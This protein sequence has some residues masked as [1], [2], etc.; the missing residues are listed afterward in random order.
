ML[1]LIADATDAGWTFRGACLELQSGELRT[2][3]GGTLGGLRAGPTGRRAAG[4]MHVSLMTRWPRSS[5]CITI[6]ATSPRSH[7]KLT[8]RVSYLERV[9]VSPASVRR[10][11]AAQG[12]TLHPASRPGPVGAQ[13]IPRLGRVPPEPDLD[14][15]HDAFHEGQVMLDEVED[16][17][18]P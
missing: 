15:R 4:P 8:Y 9:W 17:V 13:P 16:L 6:G 7:R 12:L 14:L 1:D 18:K 5:P 10:V 11:L 3:G 2:I